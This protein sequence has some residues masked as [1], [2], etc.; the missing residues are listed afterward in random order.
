MLVA[1]KM[2]PSILATTK[3][4][5]GVEEIKMKWP[6]KEHNNHHL[7]HSLLVG[8]SQMSVITWSWTPDIE[9]I[10]SQRCLRLRDLVI[11]IWPLTGL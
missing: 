4:V 10:A 9:L 5:E 6:F 11:L 7:N 1:K 2:L 8:H 3:E